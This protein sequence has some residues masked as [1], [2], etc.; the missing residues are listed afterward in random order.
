MF[1]NLLDLDKKC[2]ILDLVFTNDENIIS[3]LSYLPGLGK[4]V[5]VLLNF[6]FNCYI[7]TCSTNFKK[8][9]F[10]QRKLCSY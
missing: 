3:N 1:L 6:G 5:H 2:S 7:D 4:S 10:F 8:V 9:Q